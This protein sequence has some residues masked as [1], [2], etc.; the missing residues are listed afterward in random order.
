MQKYF[1]I[2]NQVYSAVCSFISLSLQQVKKE[3][4]K[5]AMFMKLDGKV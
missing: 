4:N 2:V 1:H 3:R 5:S